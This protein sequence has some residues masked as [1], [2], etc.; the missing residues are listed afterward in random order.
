[1]ILPYFCNYNLDY[2]RRLGF[3]KLLVWA[4]DGIRGGTDQILG[5]LRQVYPARGSARTPATPKKPFDPILLVERQENPSWLQAFSPNRLDRL[6]LWGQM[7]GLIAPTG[8]LSEWARVLLA[9]TGDGDSEVWTDRNPFLLS[10][11]DRAF[12]LHLFLYHDQVLPDLLA[13][14][15]ARNAGDRIDMHEGC[16]IVVEALGA[17]LDK[18]A[19]Q[20]IQTA[21][22]RQAVRGV[23][24]KIARDY[25]CP[26]KNALLHP[27][28]RAK[29]L[30]EMRLTPLSKKHVAEQHAICRLEQLTDLG[31]LTKE[32]PGHL[33]STEEERKQARTSRAWY[34]PDNLCHTQS[35]LIRTSGRLEDL[36]LHHWAELCGV[37]WSLDL[38]PMDPVRDQIEIARL[39]DST[40]SIARRQI[41]AIQ[42]HTWAFVTGL[43]AIRQ[44]KRL[45]FGVVFDLLDMMRRAPVYGE[46]IRH[47]GQDSYLGRTASVVGHSME[48]FI[49][50]HPLER[51]NPDGEK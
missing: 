6:V 20:G 33:P 27:D 44:G 50:A 28:S 41:G 45:E 15:A 19:G 22:V 29:A 23:L 13:I 8:R 24:E 34:I 9:F 30:Q 31:L 46:Y 37:A 11:R 12:F 3:L 10:L 51:K 2:Q 17:F 48:A 42:V 26:D 14:L 1:V 43:E 35:L 32:N 18:I 7:V 25:K 16:I 49:K 21:K 47:G 39:M 36:L 5:R 4:G 38:K 40:L